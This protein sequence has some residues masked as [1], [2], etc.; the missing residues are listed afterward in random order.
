MTA[1]TAT[2]VKTA[3]IS[4]GTIRPETI[5]AV[6]A[7]LRDG[8]KPKT[9]TESDTG[10]EVLTLTQV[11]ERLKKTTRTVINYGNAGLIKPVYGGGRSKI[12]YSRNSVL[13]F[14]GRGAQSR[15]PV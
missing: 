3:L 15:Q 4:D 6:M 5:D 10:D 7:L 1:A 13:E 12:G 14:I 2:I 11:A 9:A 8:V